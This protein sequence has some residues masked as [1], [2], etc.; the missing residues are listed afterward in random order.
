LR[1]FSVQEKDSDGSKPMNKKIKSLADWYNSPDENMHGRT[2]T[3][4][5]ACFHCRKAFAQDFN[6][7]TQPVCPDCGQ[8]M[9]YMGIRF[10][11]PRRDDK[12]AWLKIRK[13]YER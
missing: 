7:E 8:P 2:A 9:K 3:D 5:W 4:K 11:A 13:L 6:R 1:N 12:K 10:K